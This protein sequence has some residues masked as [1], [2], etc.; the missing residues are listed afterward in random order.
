MISYMHF[1]NYGDYFRSLCGELLRNNWS[2][3]SVYF[4]SSN[5]QT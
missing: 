3:I 1:G 2:F 5:Q 4:Y